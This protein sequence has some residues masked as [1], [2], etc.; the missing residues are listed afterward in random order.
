MS[1]YYQSKDFQELL[2]R[3]EVAIANGDSVYLEPDELTDLAEYYYMCGRYEASEDACDYAL[4]LFPDATEPAIFKARFALIARADIDEA[5]R[6]LASAPD[7]TILEY[8]YMS[9]E[10]LLYQG[11]PE[12]AMDYLKEV[13][14]SLGDEEDIADFSIDIA[15]LFIDYH[16]HEQAQYWL[17][18]SSEVDA[19]DYRE[20]QARIALAQGRFEEGEQILNELIDENPYDIQYWNNLALG[21]FSA[22][23]LPEAID[24]AN[25]AL[26]INPDDVEAVNTKAHVLFAQGKYE[27]ASVWFGH[28]A[29]IHPSEEN[30]FY[31]GMALANIDRLEEGIACFRKG[32]DVP[33]ER[34]RYRFRIYQELATALARHGDYAEADECA[35]QAESLAASVEERCECELI[36]AYTLL[37]AGKLKEANKHFNEALAASGHAPQM[38]LRMITS[39]CDSGY[40]ELAY[41]M[42]KWFFLTVEDSWTEGY[43][44]MAQ[45]CYDLG[46]QDEYLEYLQIASQK[47]PEETR[48]VF[49]SQ[50][51]DEVPVANYAEYA[52]QHR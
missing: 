40:L 19:A 25:F 51:P 17:S 46:Y 41:T 33:V 38:Y 11:K 5:Y 48:F 37:E 45:C 47:N 8:Y 14:A 35:R 2:Q 9:A 18:Q 49:G 22:G 4:R 13:Y 52:R 12:E 39:L 31:R 23:K 3:Y 6:H 24:A 10:L 7:K 29:E 16:F 44:Y 26:A 32:L 34:S 21:R 36:R 30:C 50:F 28:S 43:A 27:E 20:V 1:D 15:T 42:F